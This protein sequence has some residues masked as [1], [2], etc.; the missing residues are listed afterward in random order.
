LLGLIG[1]LLIYFSFSRVE[2]RLVLE[3][4]PL[5]VPTPI[6]IW[7]HAISYRLATFSFS[8]VCF[9]KLFALIFE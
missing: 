7:F 5:G 1:I 2:A 6:K 9:V 3:S 8:H 4:V